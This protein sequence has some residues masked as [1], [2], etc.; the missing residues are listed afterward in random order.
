M[1][2]GI[3]S[4]KDFEREIN[5]SGTEF[6]TTVV[7][8]P[9][10][11]ATTMIH[12]ESKEPDIVTSDVLIKRYGPGREE[13]DKNVPHSLRKIIGE[14][15]VIEGRKEALE[16]AAQFGI[17]G[18]SV[19]AYSHPDSSAN[20]LSDSNKSDLDEFVTGRKNKLTKRALAKLSMAIAHINPE[21]L[22]ELKATDLSNVAKNMAQVVKHMEPEKDKDKA[23]VAPVQ[24]LMYAPQVRNETHYETV[25]AKDNY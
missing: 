21:K 3:V 2:L 12:E 17:S 9:S 16:L 13:G 20:N 24:F 8:R 5:N 22:R 10:V 11:P 1:P 15:S 4:N 6:N 23:E 7:H 19:S 25:V 14:T 18:S